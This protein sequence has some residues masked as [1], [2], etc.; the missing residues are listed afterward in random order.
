MKKEW[1][2]ENQAR[3]LLKRKQKI[4]NTFISEKEDYFQCFSLLTNGRGDLW[5]SGAGYLNRRQTFWAQTFF[6]DPRSHL[7]KNLAKI[8]NF[9]RECYRVNTS[10]IGSTLVTQVKLEQLLESY[11]AILSVVQA[12]ER[13]FSMSIKRI[14]F[15]L[16]A[17]I[18]SFLIE[19]R[20]ETIVVYEIHSIPY[21]G[22][23]RLV[24]SEAGYQIWGR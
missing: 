3:I 21:H 22:L 15:L 10:Y 19:K 14:R 8:T 6:N 12:R 23:G 17:Y 18:S 5:G 16:V 7:C 13:I 4:K 20:N 2:P 24:R 11:L 9:T 1:D